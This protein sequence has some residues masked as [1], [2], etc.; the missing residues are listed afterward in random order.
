M[1]RSKRLH[2]FFLSD[3]QKNIISILVLYVGTV[4]NKKIVLLDFL[5]TLWPDISVKSRDSLTTF[6]ALLY[7]EGSDSLL[8]SSF[9]F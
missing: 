9:S 1:R 6:C 8:V 3:R 7:F 4:L 2:V 5:K